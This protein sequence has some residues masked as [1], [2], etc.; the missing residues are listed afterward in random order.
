MEFSGVVLNGGQSSRMGVDKGSMSVRGRPLIDISISALRESG[1]EEI[2]IV[3]GEYLEC[4]FAGVV[5]IED[6]YP[7]EG[8][9]GGVITALSVIEHDLAVI[10]SNDLLHLDPSTILKIVSTINDGDMVLPVTNGTRQVLCGV[11]RRNLL[12]VLIEAFA[13]GKRSIQSALDSIDVTEVFDIN[14]TKFQNANTPSDIIDYIAT[15]AGNNKKGM[16]V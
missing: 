4:Q 7:G 2:V 15:I 11:W 6:R 8:P 14:P 3:G 1:A 5:Q 12:P 16:D 13:D 10:L 9:L